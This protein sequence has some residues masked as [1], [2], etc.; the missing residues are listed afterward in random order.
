M[1]TI[2]K[3]LLGLILIFS[4]LSGFGITPAAAQSSYNGPSGCRS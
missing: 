1:K 3:N 2:W 4:M